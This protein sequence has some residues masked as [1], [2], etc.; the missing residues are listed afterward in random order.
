MWQLNSGLIKVT[1]T[2]NVTSKR[3]NTKHLKLHHLFL[4]P[5]S[6]IA[7]GLINNYGNQYWAA[8]KLYRH[9]Y[10]P[11]K[12][13]VYF[14][15]KWLYLHFCWLSLLFNV[16][17]SLCYI[18]KAHASI[19]L[20]YFKSAKTTSWHRRQIRNRTNIINIEYWLS[21]IRIQLV[22]E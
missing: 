16:L 10:V 6:A 14:L 2:S 5:Q 1:V 9:K 20:T 7:T 15:F 13:T 19:V 17:V 4:V 3:V 11:F 12:I 18:L 22:V 8:F 21:S